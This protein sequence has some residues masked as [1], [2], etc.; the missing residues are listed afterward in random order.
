[1]KL[2]SF[3]LFCIYEQYKKRCWAC[4]FTNSIKWGT[5]GGKQ[6]Y[7]CKNCGILFTGSNPSVT[8]SNRFIW[9]KKWVLYRYTLEQL[10]QESGYSTRTLKRLFDEYLSKP[11]KLS[12]YPSERVNLMIDGT[13]FSNDLCL[14]LYRD[15]TIKF[16]QLYRLTDGEWFEELF[17]DLENLQ[18]LGVQIESITC[19]GHKALLKAIQLACPNVTTQRCLVH[20]QRM[21]RIWLSSK[22]KSDA[23]KA[24]RKIMSVLHTVDSTTKRDY[25]IVSLH[26][27]HN[28][29]KDYIN[30]KTI[31]EETGRYWYTHK[32]VRRSF[33]V[34]KRALPDM[35]HFLD[36]PRIPKSTNGLESFFGHLKGHLNVHRGLSSKHKRQFIQWYLYFKNQAQVFLAIKQA[37]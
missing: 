13:Y 12:V 25:W 5:Q 4:G 32:M 1:M 20:I 23:G 9:F 21:C 37:E 14:V 33:S 26:K 15:S 11:P 7:K 17:E 28:A 10:S 2:I 35:F 3:R 34:V 19:D 31:N 24:L 29:F 27:W 36:N 30:E 16:T 6:R 8:K 22:P 18:R